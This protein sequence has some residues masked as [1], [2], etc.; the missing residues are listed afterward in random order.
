MAMQIALI[1]YG[2]G[3]IHSAQKALALAAG[4]VGIVAE[5]SLVREAGGLA[6]ADYI[7]LPG[8]GSFGACYEGLFAI[9]DMEGVLCEQVLQKGKP[10]LGI[11]VGMQLLAE[12]SSEYG[13]HK[14]L[15]WIGGE[16]EALPAEGLKVPHMGWNEIEVTARGRGHPVLQ[17]L[18]AHHAYFVHSFAFHPKEERDCLAVCE[19]GVSFAAIVG[20]DNVVGTQF[21]PEKSQRLGGKILEN[22]LG[23]K[24]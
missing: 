22:F 24:P 16:V 1:D 5:V 8:V 15:G 2:C 4:E 18:G 9:E 20:R 11:C 17:G 21:H 3:N 12:R 6:S 23:W 19:Y 7:I 13:A 14:G 10:F